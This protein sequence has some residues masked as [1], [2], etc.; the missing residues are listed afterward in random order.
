VA[1]NERLRQALV[2]LCRSELSPGDQL[3][4]ERE[5][6]EEYD[7]SRTTVRD[8]VGRLV[9]DGLLVR[10]PGKGTF[11]AERQIR[12]RLHLAS[13]HEDMRRLGFTPT[14]VVFSAE[15]ADPPAATTAALGLRARDRAYHVRRLLLADQAPVGLDDAWYHAG[16]LPGLLQQDLKGSIYEA[17]DT[18]FG[19]RLD[20]AEQTVR[21][22]AADEVVAT[23]LGI[24]PDSPVFLFDRTSFHGDTALEHTR[25]WYRSDR[26][27]LQMSLGI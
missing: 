10:V 23:L 15:I 18:H 5:L 9:S 19:K 3:P 20:R 25:S 21:A 27:E 24:P 4:S 12:S 7:V 1:K 11:V 17:V 8:A 16:E 14:T 6:C 22:V 26:Y 2:A 13:F